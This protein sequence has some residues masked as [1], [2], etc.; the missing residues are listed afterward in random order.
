M[1]TNPFSQG[2]AGSAQSPLV[3]VA[4]ALVDAGGRVL[5]LRRRD[6]KEHGGLWEFP[7]GKVEA[8]ESPPAALSR[9]LAEELCI[10]VESTAFEPLSFASSGEGAPRPIVLL[11]YACREWRGTPIVPAPDA[12]AGAAIAWHTAEELA[13]LADQSDGMPPLDVPLAKAVVMMLKCLAK[14]ESHP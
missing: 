8:G 6:D 14:R 9:E 5:V 4:A 3:V 13:Q 7:G 10:D 11:L 1:L 2:G 12:A